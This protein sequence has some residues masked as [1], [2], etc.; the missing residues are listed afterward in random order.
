MDV[1]LGQQLL[2]EVRG[3]VGDDRRCSPAGSI[4]D[5]SHAAATSDRTPSDSVAPMA[6]D[7]GHRGHG[8]HRL[9]PGAA[10]SPSAATSCACWSAQRRASRARRDRVRARDRRRH[11]SPRGPPGDGGGRARLSRRRAHLDAA[12]RPRARSSRSTSRGARNVFEEA[13]ERRRRARS[14]SPRSVARDRARAKPGGTADED[15]ARSATAT[16]GSPTSTP[17]TRPSS[18]RCA[19]PP[20][21]LAVVIVNPTF[22][23][24]PDDP[25]GTSM[26]LVRRFLL[27]PDPGLRR[28]RRSTSSTSATSRPA[29]C[30]P[31]SA[32]TTASATSSAGAT[33]PSTACSPT[34]SRIS[35]VEPPPLK[36]PLRLALA[37]AETG[38]RAAGCRC[39]ISADEVRSAALWWTYRN[40]EGQA[41]ARASRRARTRRRSR[42]RSPGSWTAARRR[43]RRAT[44]I[45]RVAPAARPARGG[46]GRR[47]GW[48]DGDRR[49]SIAARRPPT[50]SVRAA[51]SSAACAGSGS[52]TGPSGSPIGGRAAPRSRS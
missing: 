36:L 19:R 28:R 31:T 46:A 32:A 37:G 30:S 26:S 25:T 3:R 14:S 4:S 29:T 48:R 16:W 41:R 44:G 35:G 9:A 38:R 51:R 1:V 18:R 33:S 5:R 40:D 17:S 8:L 45:E 21:G 6:T 47:E 50:S 13:L 12:A 34:S 20:T 43:H 10:R 39:P 15:A 22:V 7:A 49:S 52:S 23:L 2:G 11:R 24:G 27:R 42:R